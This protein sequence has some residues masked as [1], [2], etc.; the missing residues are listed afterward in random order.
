MLGNE[1]R[2]AM[3]INDVE[4]IKLR[5]VTTAKGKNDASLVIKNVTELSI[6]DCKPLNDIE[7]KQVKAKSY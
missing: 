7:I 5:N 6:K 4:G 2:P 3:I 1:Q